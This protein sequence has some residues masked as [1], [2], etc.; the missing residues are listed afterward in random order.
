MNRRL[1]A[2]LLSASIG[3][4]CLTVPVSAATDSE[5]KFDC[6]GDGSLVL[7][8]D[9]VAS[10]VKMFPMPDSSMPYP[11][12]INAQKV[13]WWCAGDGVCDWELDRNTGA[14][15]HRTEE[16]RVFERLSCAIRKPD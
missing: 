1:R 6:G 12:K 7:T 16:F 3:V 2:I 14:A 4:H 5:I 11:A 9:L 8:V 10:T 13:Q 15:V